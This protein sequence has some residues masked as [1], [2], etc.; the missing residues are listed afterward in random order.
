MDAACV[1]H[2]ALLGAKGLLK[3]SNEEELKEQA[4]AGGDEHVEE[5]YLS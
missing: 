5:L 2:P 4:E 3:S 1:I